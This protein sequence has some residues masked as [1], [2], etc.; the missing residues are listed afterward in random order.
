[1]EIPDQ[2]IDRLDVEQL[3][4]LE[5]T[6]WDRHVTGHPDHTVFHRGAWARV[7]HKSYGH[8][9]VYLRFARGG[10]TKAL[11]PVMEVR[12]LLTGHR[13]VCL[14]FSDFCQPLVRDDDDLPAVRD[15]LATVATERGW[16]HLEI[17]GGAPA[18]G[19][20][21][22]ASAEKTFFGHELKLETAEDVQF[23]LFPGAVRR[24]IRKA[25]RSGV[26]VSVSRSWEAVRRFFDLHVR[27]RR[28]HG[29]PPQPLSFFREVFRE[30]IEAG[31]G[32]V[33]IAE[34]ENRP[35][36]G[37]VFL[38]SGKSALYKFG[39]SDDAAL[40]L[41]P[42][43]LVMWEGIRT[44]IGTGCQTLHF[45]RSSGTNAGLRRF[46]RSWGA[47]EF[48][49]QYTRF[50]P[51]DRAWTPVQP[52]SPGFHEQV[53]RRLPLALNRLAGKVIYPQLD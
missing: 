41:R 3:D 15:H 21:A 29:A 5:G 7:L 34:T 27:T 33:V 11:V 18:E 14:P 22:G 28:R 42:N 48:G 45:G 51:S 50:R 35:V 49:I 10:I 37:A 20:R 36:A 12:R 40:G 8:D 31:H 2:R 9:P 38:H 30:L 32:F 19:G 39:A 52:D 53:F 44:L 25:E 17:R 26:T 23:S 13:G 24:A 1:M 46:K 43:N 4:P 6:D 47:S 16:K